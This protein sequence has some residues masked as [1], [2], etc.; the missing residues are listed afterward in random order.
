MHCTH[1]VFPSLT[2]FFLQ[3][4][5]SRNDIPCAILNDWPLSISQHPLLCSMHF[6]HSL[7]PGKIF[8]FMQFPR[9]LKISSFSSFVQGLCCFVLLR[10]PAIPDDKNRTIFQY[11]WF[12]FVITI[13]IS[14]NVIGCLTALFLPNYSVE[15]SSDT[16]NRTAGCNRTVES[17][18]HIALIQ[19][20]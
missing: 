4:F 7:F 12:R 15:L 19:L 13:T 18:N 9:C 1:S 14:S 11:C 16:C 10:A 5:C 17:A 6:K 2:I 3:C 8:F 20:N